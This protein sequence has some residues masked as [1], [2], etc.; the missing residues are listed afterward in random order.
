MVLHL[1][2]Y[3][4]LEKKAQTWIFKLWTVRGG[5][6][7]SEPDLRWLLWPGAK[8]KQAPMVEQPDVCLHTEAN[9]SCACMSAQ[10][11][12][13]VTDSCPKCPAI[14]SLKDKEKTSTD[15][16]KISFKKDNS[17]KRLCFFSIMTIWKWIRPACFPSIRR[18]IRP[19]Q[20][21]SF[22]LPHPWRVSY[23]ILVKTSPVLWNTQLG[24]C[25][26]YHCPWL[27][28]TEASSFNATLREVG[29]GFSHFFF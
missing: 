7:H 11:T 9:M 23:N 5:F 24:V 21:H 14:R 3:A 16:F 18:S 27:P 12:V 8:P 6:V 20:L 4:L 17:L 2:L 22:C 25:T 13:Y 29:I 19:E 10:R 1:K 28:S 26:E 15:V